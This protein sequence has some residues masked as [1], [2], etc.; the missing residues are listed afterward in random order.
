MHQKAQKYNIGLSFPKSI[1]SSKM[2]TR[3]SILIS[4]LLLLTLNAFA[5]DLSIKEDNHKPEEIFTSKD[6]DFLQLWHYDQI[7]K[8]ELNEKDRD[9]YFSRLNQYTFNMSSLGLAKYSFTDHER[10][11]A[12]K[13]LADKLDADMKKYLSPENYTIHL[14]TFNKIEHI[15]YEKRNWSY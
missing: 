10:Q 8:M 13:N 15:V 4:I 12:F 2:K 6:K 1:K 5:K 11:Q 7:L 9:E 3:H 14:E